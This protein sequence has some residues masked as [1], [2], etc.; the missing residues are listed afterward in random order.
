LVFAPIICAF[1]LVC[2]I[3]PATAPAA[4]TP[5]WKSVIADWSKDS[6]IDGRY[7]ASC[8]RQA[9]QNAPTDLKIYS[10]L[11][12][13][14]QHALASRSTRRLAGVHAPAAVIDTAGNSSSFSFLVALIAGLGAL[15]AACALAATLV[16]RRS[17]H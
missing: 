16:R 9:M 6:S 8:Y 13:D 17:A 14:L 4:A 2:G 3:M 10:N 5:C 1:S 15:L 7:A 11:E 12:D